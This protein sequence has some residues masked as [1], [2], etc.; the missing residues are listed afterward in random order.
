MEFLTMRDGK[1]I[2]V[3][4][5]ED[6]KSPRAAVVLVHGMCEYIGRYDDFCKYL[7]SNGYYVIGMDNRS[8]GDTDPDR[9]GSG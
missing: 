9:L 3:R 7:N 5:W 6:V 8:F 2:A 1:S 4:Y